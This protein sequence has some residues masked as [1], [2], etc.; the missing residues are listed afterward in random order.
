VTTYLTICGHRVV[1]QWT[2]SKATQ[3]LIQDGKKF[4][5]PAPT[6]EG[7]PQEAGLSSEM[8]LKQ[9][10][11]FDERDTMSSNGGWPAHNRQL[12]EQPMVLVVSIGADVSPSSCSNNTLG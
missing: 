3:F 10:L 2:G 1:T 12:L 8:C 6:W 4:D 11:V 9:P 7:L 5:I